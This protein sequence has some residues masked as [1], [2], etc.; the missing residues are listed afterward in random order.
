MPLD[1]PELDD[2]KFQDIV[3]EAKRLIPRY[4]K[5]WTNHNLSDPGVALIELFAW[6]SEMILFRLNQ[7]PDRLYTKFLDLVGIEP[8]PPSVARADITF[9]LSA[10]L[11]H[12]VTVA[13]G[14]EVATLPV[15]SEG[16]QVVFTTT[17]DLVIAPPKL[18]AAKTGRAGDDQL[19]ADA[20]DDL[21][22]EDGK[23]ACFTSDPIT[24]GDAVYFGFE[25]SLAGNLLNL[26]ISAPIK[27]RGIIPGDPPIRWEV[28]AG[29]SWV[30]MRTLSDTTGGLNRD[31]SIR[32]L[33]PGLMEPL[34]LGDTRAHWMR[35]VLLQARDGQPP[36][37]SS[38]EITSLRVDSLGGTVRAEHATAVGPETLGRSDGSPGQSFTTAHAPVLPGGEGEGIRIVT[39]TGTTE[40]Q[41]VADFTESGT[42]VASLRA[43]RGQRH[44]SFRSVRPIPGWQHSPARGDTTR[45]RGGRDAPLPPRRGSGGQRRGRHADR[46]AYQRRLHRPGVQSGPRRRRS[47]R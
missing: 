22:F 15:S 46:A 30:S 36:Y 34:S 38:P 42:P 20:W 18:F 24:P 3:D 21:R 13:V 7:V 16:A 25:D 10:V 28:W 14:T 11:D 1:V 37:E 32:L 31:G 4:C 45:R 35:A 12:P 17:R 33:V 47:G 41:E 40:W 39:T 44:G 26:S 2:R 6:M 8:F 29:E 9:W 5:E 43:R 23:V 27:G 19:L